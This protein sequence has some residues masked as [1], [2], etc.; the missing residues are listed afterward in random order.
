M[1]DAAYCRF[2]SEF[3]AGLS[4]DTRKALAS[5]AR[6]ENYKKDQV[7]TS[8]SSSVEVSMLHKLSLAHIAC[9]SAALAG[10]GGVAKLFSLS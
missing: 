2:V 8:S 6:L 1:H 10:F 3:L 4:P 9:S 5:V 7:S